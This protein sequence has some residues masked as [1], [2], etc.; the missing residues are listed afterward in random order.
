MYAGFL[1]FV[2]ISANKNDEKKISLFLI[3]LYIL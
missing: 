1:F 3:T 2:H